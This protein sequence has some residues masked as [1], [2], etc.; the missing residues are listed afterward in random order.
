M[1]GKNVILRSDLEIISCHTKCENDFSIS[2]NGQL[3][4]KM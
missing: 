2:R 3:F 1:C 4:T